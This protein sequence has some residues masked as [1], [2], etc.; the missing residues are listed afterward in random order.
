LAGLPGT[1]EK[2]VASYQ[3]NFLPT[4]NS[5]LEKLFPLFTEGLGGKNVHLK[6]SQ[7][8]EGDCGQGQGISAKGDLWM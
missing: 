5:T 8:T 7:M 1:N 3:K 6:S 4:L 2:H